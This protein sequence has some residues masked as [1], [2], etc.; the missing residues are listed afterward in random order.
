MHPR[1]LH[2]CQV[3]WGRWRALY[4]L[5]KLTISV[6]NPGLIVREQHHP[7]RAQPMHPRAL[8]L[9]QVS[10]GRWRALYVLPKLTISVL[11]PG[12]IGSSCAAGFDR[13]WRSLRRHH[14][15][16]SQ[17]P[18]LHLNHLPSSKTQD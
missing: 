9:C 6:L 16:T 8:H 17:Q 11:N 1:A 7:L 10:W 13:Y 14:K 4:V 3:S 15:T 18:W 5:P 12:L 2:L